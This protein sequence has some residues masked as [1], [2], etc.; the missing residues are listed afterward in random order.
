MVFP[1]PN[2]TRIKVR[3][4]FVD[5]AKAAREETSYGLTGPVQFIPTPIVAINQGSQQIIEM[6]PFVTFPDPQDGYF[7][8]M[9]PSTDDP[10]VVPQE[11]NY[12]VVEPTGRSYYIVVPYDT[13]FLVD[14]TDIDVGKQ[15]ID[16]VDVV[17]DPE[18]N[19]G[20][21]QL[22]HGRPGRDITSITIDENFHLVGT[23]SDLTDWDAGLLSGVRS[24]NTR[25]GDV[26]LA[27]A[28][29]GLANVDNTA[30]SA[31]PVS[32]AQATAIN[33]AVTAHTGATDP[34]PQY[35]TPAEGSAAYAALSHNHAA[36]AINAGQL[37]TD[38]LPQV[39]STVRPFPA[40]TGTVNIDASL[41]GNLLDYT[42]TG[43]VTFAVPTGGT[44]R[45]VLR[46][47]VLAS[48]AARNVV[49]NAAY[50]LS[51]GLSSRT[52]AVPSGQSLMA[53]V[54]FSTLLNAWVITAATVTA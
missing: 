41:I 3:G 1:I 15:V 22:L 50:R 11:W 47:Q 48:G 30:D 40:S 42:A 53:A 31:K 20:T 9:L 45:Q 13:P 4:H 28:D 8:I 37:A 39:A 2:Y 34:H 26:L 5:L 18:S 29:V 43:D 17:P 6:K 35:L 19:A 10:D 54:E 14:P 24:V 33:A 21:I 52:F 25:V 32:T 38:R 36:S 12:K 44:N 49:F 16:L 46:I 27:K 23:Y 51:T 7:E